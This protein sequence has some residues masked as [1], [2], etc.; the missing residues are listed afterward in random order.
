[1]RVVEESGDRVGRQQ[2]PS[3]FPYHPSP[4]IFNPFLDDHLTNPLSAQARVEVLHYSQWQE[5]SHCRGR[6]MLTLPAASIIRSSTA[7]LFVTEEPVAS[8]KVVPGLAPSP[9]PNTA[10]IRTLKRFRELFS[11]FSFS[12]EYLSPQ[13]INQPQWR[14]KFCLHTRKF[15]FFLMKNTAVIKQKTKDPLLDHDLLT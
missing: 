6:P 5:P 3:A 13:N 15:I 10:G 1:M 11:A 12:S 7:P 14:S 2:H 8:D 9:I 4:S